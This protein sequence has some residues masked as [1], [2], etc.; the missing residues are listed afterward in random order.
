M[1]HRVK[2]SLMQIVIAVLFC[3]CLSGC[4]GETKT[5]TGDASVG[6]TSPDSEPGDE[7][8]SEKTNTESDLTVDAVAPR[9]T[10]R[11]VIPQAGVPAKLV[12]ERQE[13]IDYYEENK[14]R[15]VW[16]V[17]IYS[18]NRVVENGPSVE[19]Y[20]NGT[21]FVE[22]EYGDGLRVGDWKFWYPDGQLAKEGQYS[23][24]K[25]HGAWRK[26]REDGTISA[27]E[28]YVGGTPDG[29]WNYYLSDGKTMLQQNE[30]RAGKPNGT[31]TTWYQPGEDHQG[32]LQ[33]ANLLNYKDGVLDGEQKYW[34]ENGQQAMVQHFSEGKRHGKFFA[35]DQLGTPRGES[36]F[37]NGKRLTAAKED[38]P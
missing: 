31:W 35:W 15:R 9:I 1:T 18:D 6:V 20:L 27:E 34:H 37:E 5:E 11:T 21:K 7:A 24:D 2:F 19:F 3:A 36:E 26:Y 16:H 22:G 12:A 33:Q 8:K 32:P 25:V 17:N 23:E 14:P 4:R 30:F 13:Q 38:S 10:R 28:N 29:Q